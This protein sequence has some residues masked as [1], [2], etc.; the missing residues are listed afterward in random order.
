MAIEPGVGCRIC[1]FCKSG[2]Y[3]LCPDMI[4]CATPPVDGNLSRYYVHDADFCYKWVTLIYLNLVNSF[5]VV[6]ILPIWII[7]E[8]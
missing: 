7:I 4:F 5:K 6:L 2:D 1:D 8:D 3:H